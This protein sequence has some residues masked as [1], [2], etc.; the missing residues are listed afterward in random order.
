MRVHRENKDTVT[1]EAAVAFAVNE[2]EQVSSPLPLLPP[3]GTCTA[4]TGSFQAETA[5]LNSVS[6]VLMS[7]IAGRGLDAGPGIKLSRDLESRTIS[8]ERGAA[9]YYRGRLGVGGANVNPRARGLILDPG[10][11]ALVGTGGAEVGAFRAI[12]PIG[13]S[14]EWSNREE[15]GVV[16]RGRPLSLEWHDASTDR[17]MII[18]ATN[19]DRVTTATGTCLCVANSGAGHFVIPSSL[20]GNLPASV[21][22]GTPL[23][24][25]LYLA[26]MSARKGSAIQASGLSRGSIVSLNIVGR[27]VSYR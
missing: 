5:G 15:S 11:Y 12:F 26:S 22:T 21:D 3:P 14:F 20:L 16:D 18:L 23:Y 13:P 4:Y 8:R 7:Q 1:D 24:D 17:V 6:A 10:D 19:T 27:F 9:G 2:H 25:R